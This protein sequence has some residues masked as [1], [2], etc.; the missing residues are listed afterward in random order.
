MN[1]MSFHGAQM[2]LYIAEADAMEGLIVWVRVPGGVHKSLMPRHGVYLIH[3]YDS[4]VQIT[5]ALI[6]S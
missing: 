2:P 1:G 5:L 6:V 4:L 3:Q